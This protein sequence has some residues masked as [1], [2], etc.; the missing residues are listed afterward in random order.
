[1]NKR[2][3]R[4]DFLKL[5]GVTSAGLALSACGVKA[6]EMPVLTNT[7][8][9]TFTPES[10]KTPIP[11]NTPEPTATK[12]PK[13]LRDFAERLGF[14]IGAIVGGYGF[15]N[16][17]GQLLQLQNQEFNLGM[18]YLDM[19]LTQPN[20]SEFTLK[21]QD[22]DF[23][24]TQKFGMKSLG[25]PLIWFDALPDWVKSNNFSRDDLIGVMVNHITSMMKHYKGKMNSW[26]VVNEAYIDS[27][28]IFYNKIGADYVEIA[29]ETARNVDPS[30]I[31]IYNEFDNHIAKGKYTEH[32]HTIVDKL[33]SRGL[34]DAVG[35][36]MHLQGNTPP[37]KQDVIATMKSYDIPVYVTEFDVN[38]K[39]VGG[40]QENRFSQQAIIY[41][42]MLEAALES[43]AC[44]DFLIFGLVD[45]LSVWE[46]MPGL[47]AYSANADP[48]PFDD[49]FQPKP[50]YFAMLDVFKNALG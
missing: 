30:A 22:S 45:K 24:L 23:S 33:K 15:A 44:K 10:T 19:K 26:V 6:T 46:T 14:N 48:L 8:A 1:M 28:D 5:A 41:K 11:S 50:A 16:Y 17:Y 36:Q 2:L 38:M 42:D 34:I 20:Q 32:T 18:V 43:Q 3:S 35:L 40:T 7:P 47:W 9:Q 21:D 29:F 39:D 4:R 31:L 12:T 25:H 49:N 37:D 27:R 13:T